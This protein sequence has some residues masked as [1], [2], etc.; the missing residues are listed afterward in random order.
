MDS[1]WNSIKN[2][3]LYLTWCSSMP[4]FC[5]YCL[6]SFWLLIL[7]GVFFFLHCTYRQSLVSLVHFPHP[8]WAIRNYS[9]FRLLL[10]LLLLHFVF[11]VAWNVSY[12]VRDYNVDFIPGCDVV[13]YVAS[14]STW[15]VHQTS[16]LSI[17]SVYYQLHW[18]LFI[19]S[20]GL[21]KHVLPKFLS[22]HNLFYAKC[23]FLDIKIAMGKILLQ[24][25][26]K[27]ERQ[28]SYRNET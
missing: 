4:S 5:L 20:H 9:W 26:H 11:V 13:I 17:Q 8:G 1:S 21:M 2:S 23:N 24:H 22:R 19:T 27:S 12:L 28:H 6:R 15:S 16:E 3:I 10:L 14:T 25:M 7:I 18:Y